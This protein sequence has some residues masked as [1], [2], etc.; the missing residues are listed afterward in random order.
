VQLLYVCGYVYELKKKMEDKKRLE[1]VCVV[2]LFLNKQSF[3][4]ATNKTPI[5]VNSFYSV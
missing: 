1:V 2:C 5:Y 4:L 3:D